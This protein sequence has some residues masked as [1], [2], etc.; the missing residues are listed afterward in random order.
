MTEIPPPNEPVNP[1]DQTEAQAKE[2]HRS[3]LHILV[4]TAIANLTT[5]YLWFGLT[6]WVYLETENVMA[7][8]IIGGSYMLLIAFFAMVFG[9]IIDR[10][11][12]KQVFVF[13]SVFTAVAFGAAGLLY[14]WLPTEL[15]LNIGGPQF[16]L[17]S[18]VILVGAVVEQMRSIAL[19]TTVTLLVP[20]ER[21]ANAN[22]LVG[23]VQGIAFIITSVFSGLSIGLLGMGWTL[24]LAFVLICLTLVHV[25]TI[26]L[27]EAT[28][29]REPGRQKI[30]DFRNSYLAVIAIPGLI[31]LIIFSM[32]NNFIGGVY[33]AL[34]DPYGL[35]IM[36][37]EAWGITFGLASTGF[38][39]GGSLIAKFGLGKNPIRTLLL[40][41]MA[42]GALGALFTIREW[43]WLFILGIWLYM[44]LIPAVEAAEQTVIQKV[45]P[46]RRQGR[47]FGF[48]Q[49]VEA[50]AAPITAFIIAPIAQ[51]GI[52]PFMRSEEGRNSFGWLLG[53]GDTRGIALVFL[54]AG[55]IMVLVA[56]LAMTTKQ[57]RRLS[58]TF[59]TS[60]PNTAT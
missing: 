47:V 6:F 16:W 37:V 25:L 51:Y 58:A 34:M 12:K 30:I 49:M 55:L 19:S 22:G 27:P 48:A 57:Y 15:I 1:Q 11:R 18:G 44:A 32:F 14:V 13:S 50:S 38:I 42:M 2:G 60:S 9:T 45:V 7:T 26:S 8:G 4:N 33:M 28:P 46:Y 40:C 59:A 31:A 17:F 20:V 21:H 53:G 23:T 39:L 54:V 36:S 35:S 52:I 5:S 3:F 41:V 56:L 24:L 29:E 43:T 10:Y